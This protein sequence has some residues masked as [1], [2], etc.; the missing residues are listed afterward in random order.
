VDVLVDA[1]LPEACGG[2]D[3]TRRSTADPTVVV[4]VDLAL[5]LAARV[6]PKSACAC[7]ARA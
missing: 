6:R 2:D 5:G 1:V 4:V 3:E 7:G